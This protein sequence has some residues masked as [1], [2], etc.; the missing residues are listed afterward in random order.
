MRKHVWAIASVGGA[1]VTAVLLTL[2]FS[3]PTPTGA[4]HAAEVILIILGVSFT[5]AALWLSVLALQEVPRLYLGEPLMETLQIQPKDGAIPSVGFTVEPQVPS[6]ALVTATPAAETGPAFEL[7]YLHVFNRPKKGAKRAKGVFVRLDFRD[8]TD[9]T[10]VQ[11]VW[12]QW[13][14][15]PA[16][17]GDDATQVAPQV[18]IPAHGSG[19]RLDVVRRLPDAA[20]SHATAGS[21]RFVGWTAVPLGAGPLLVR[22]IA[23][24]ADAKTVSA[25]FEVSHDETESTLRLVPVGPPSWRRRLKP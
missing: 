9:G 24:G 2:L 22:V 21:S 13:S 11:S 19:I 5:I 3:D 23:R 16:G 7:A 18:D 17:S 15:G 20:A 10:P 1:V 8:A 12:A 14:L 6:E 25:W 4:T